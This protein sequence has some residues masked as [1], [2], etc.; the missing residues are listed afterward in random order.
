MSRQ[1]T[2]AAMLGAALLSVALAGSQGAPVPPEAKKE[3]PPAKGKVEPPGAPL[4]A[5]LIAN[6]AV[7]ALD[8]SGLSPQQYLEAAK[9]KPPRVDVDLV[10]EL[11]NTAATDIKIWIVDDYHNEQRQAGGDYVRL[12]LKLDGPGAVSRT[13][14]RRD[15]APATPP[16]KVLTLKPGKSF[17]LPITSLCYGRHGVATFEAERACWT[18][19][20]DY[21][22]SA[23]YQTAVDPAPKGSKPTRWAGFDG[24]HVTVS[25]APVKI[26]VAEAKNPKR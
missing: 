14:L 3:A 26:K 7:Y 10:L 24:G 5:R 23:T 19:A 6:K 9:A 16:P 2:F 4:E 18:K 8:R 20:G 25:T 1:R 11:R 22:L 21:T 13:V 17:R 12:T 15:T